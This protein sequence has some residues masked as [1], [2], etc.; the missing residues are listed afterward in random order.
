MRV[1]VFIMQQSTMYIV[2]KIYNQ[3][4]FSLVPCMVSHQAQFVCFVTKSVEVKLV[5]S[6][7]I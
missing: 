2:S 4:L 7:D 6:K 3:Q 5:I 1:N